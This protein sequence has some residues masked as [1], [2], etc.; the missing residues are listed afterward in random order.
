MLVH[1]DVFEVKKINDVECKP[2]G[3][4]N[5][6]TDRFGAIFRDSYVSSHVIIDI[7]CYRDKYLLSTFAQ[8]HTRI[9]LRFD[10][11]T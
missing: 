5:K 4:L 7:T 8:T 10:Y 3:L 1:I 9:S 11:K 2:F 6:F